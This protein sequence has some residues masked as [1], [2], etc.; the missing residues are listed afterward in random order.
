MLNSPINSF[1]LATFCPFSISHCFENEAV[2]ACSAV[3]HKIARIHFENDRTDRPRYKQVIQPWAPA[4]SHQKQS[5]L[6]RRPI[7]ESRDASQRRA[8][9]TAASKGVV[10]SRTNNSP[11]SLLP[12]KP[13]CQ[14]RCL[15][16]SHGSSPSTNCQHLPS[17]HQLDNSNQA[18]N[19]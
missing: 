5:S 10:I 4:V 15:H 18:D 14:Q 17:N 19:Q 12:T 7:A 1:F 13:K 3:A 9:E 2:I 8:Q 16:C 11:S 6:C